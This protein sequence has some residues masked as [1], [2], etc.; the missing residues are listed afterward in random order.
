MNPLLLIPWVVMTT[1]V[2]LAMPD[3]VP[4]AHG[5]IGR[6]GTPLPSPELQEMYEDA[7]AQEG[8]IPGG[9]SLPVT[10]P[11]AMHIVH[12]SSG[13]GD[14]PDYMIAD[15]IQ[16][17]N[18]AY[19][20]RGF[21]FALDSIDRTEN[22]DW[23]RNFID[24]EEEIFSNLAID[25]AHTLNIYISNIPYLGYA[26]LPGSWLESSHMNAAVLLHTSLPGGGGRPYDEGDTA[27]HEVGHYLGLLHTF[28]GGCNGQGDRVMDTPAEANQTF[29]CPI[30]QD[31]CPGEGQDPIRNFMD[32]T[33]DAC[34][35]EFT[36]GQRE[37]MLTEC[38]QF[39]PSLMENRCDLEIDLPEYEVLA[40]PGATLELPV[41]I[42]N[43][44]DEALDFDA[45][46]LDIFGP[47]H[48][49]D[50]MEWRQGIFTSAH[51]SYTWLWRQELPDKAPEG[52]YQI[53][54]RLYVDGKRLWSDRCRVRVSAG[55]GESE[56]N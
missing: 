55:S 35:W 11:V 26:Y 6:C 44:C 3:L 39:R 22:N 20:G 47:V 13:R 12:N 41:K 40:S 45:I 49:A 9:R 5:E 37:R 7:I 21:Q 18:D 46:E 48:L 53:R 4:Y 29:G 24:H 54:M 31:S 16:V 30:G 36:P 27:T 1:P 56:L 33:D 14:V 51:I 32:Y 23:Y 19:Y 42:H 28:Q 38:A 25:P 50:G 2:P 17:L 34:M 10:L 15:Q 8:G 43:F 52:L